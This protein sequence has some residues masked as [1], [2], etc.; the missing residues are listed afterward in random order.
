M[1]SR[2]RA[3]GDNFTRDRPDSALSLPETASRFDNFDRD[4]ARDLRS[5]RLKLLRRRSLA[6]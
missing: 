6:E 1:A 5:G 2:M 3:S 4:D